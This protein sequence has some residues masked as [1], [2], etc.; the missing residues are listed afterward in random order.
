MGGRVN[1][2]RGD[3]RP[4]ALAGL[5]ENSGAHKTFDD[6][7][8]RL[9]RDLKRVLQPVNR[10]ERRAAMDDFL[11]NGPDDLGPASGITTIEFHN[12]SLD[13]GGYCR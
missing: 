2:L 11:E 13:S 5:D 7:G 12:A 10:D 9:G 8:R 4:D 3:P 6:A 1:R